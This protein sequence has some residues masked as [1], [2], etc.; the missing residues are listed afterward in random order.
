M[1]AAARSGVTICRKRALSST[2]MVK[3]LTAT[4]IR[5]NILIIWHRWHT[6]PRVGLFRDTVSKI[7]SLN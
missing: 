3:M 5:M 6:L 7:V 1:A 4:A 2:T